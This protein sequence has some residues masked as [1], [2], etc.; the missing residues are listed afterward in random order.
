MKAIVCTRYGPPEVLQLREVPK[1]IPKDNEV[2][3]KIHATSV[4]TGDSN[5]RDFVY[6]PPGLGL[7]ARLMLGITK[8]KKSMLGSVFAGEIE[9]VGKD[10]KLFNVG[11]RIFGGDGDG[12]GAYAEYKCMSED[13][14]LAAKPANLTYEEAAVIPFGAL[15]S[16]YFLRD[17]ANVRNGQKVLV[18]GASGGVGTSAVQIAKAFGAEVTGVCSTRNL[19]LVTSLGVDKVIDYTK[20]DFTKNGESYDIILDT[21]V[22]TTS[23]SKCKKSLSQDGFYLA[24]AGGLKD[25]F[26]MLWTSRI[27]SKKVIFGGGGACE[28]KENLF[29]LKELLESGK[30]KPVLDR[31]YPLEQIAEAFNY[32]EKGQ[33]KGNVAITVKHNDEK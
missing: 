32:L 18:N 22:G 17:R 31:S 15:T 27:G 16:L 23:F 21:A 3:I 26:Q 30:L 13:G 14:L 4:T 25:L 5:A 24:V 29:F 6:I 11:D 12:M 2:L 1:P 20:E 9:A 28:K 10:V 19:E 7:L 33:K 8:P